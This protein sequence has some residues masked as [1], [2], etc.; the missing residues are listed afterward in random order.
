MKLELEKDML[1]GY[2]AIALV[3][4]MVGFACISTNFRSEG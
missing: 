4:T 2:V 1:L 3:F